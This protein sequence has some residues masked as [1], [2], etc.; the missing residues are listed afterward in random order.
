MLDI[1]IIQGLKKYN[2]ELSFK[3]ARSVYN[4]LIEFGVSKNQLSYIGYGFSKP[5]EDNETEI[6]RSKNRRTEIIY[7]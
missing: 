3:R 2:Q 7:D 1:L 4:K 5:V 6:G